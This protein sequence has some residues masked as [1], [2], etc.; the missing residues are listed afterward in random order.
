MEAARRLAPD[1]VLMDVRMPGVDGIEA[2]RRLG[3][4]G[5]QS[6]RVLMLTTFDLD[7]YVYDV[8]RCVAQSLRPPP[9]KPTYHHQPKTSPRTFQ[10]NHN[11]TPPQAPP[12]AL[13]PP[14]PPPPPPKPGRD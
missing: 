8:L 5:P 4:I 2:T 10:E 1:V 7:E 14:P 12:P 3:R 11:Q 6:P 9:P 13:E